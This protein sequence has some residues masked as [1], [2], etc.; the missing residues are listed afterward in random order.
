M[1]VGVLII[2]IKV[3]FFCVCKYKSFG[4]IDCIYCIKFVSV[5]YNFFFNGEWFFFKFF[6]VLKGYFCDDVNYFVSIFF[7]NFESNE[8]II[9]F[10]YRKFDCIRKFDIN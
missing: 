5:L 4:N 10:V 6:F 2:F 8:L 3:V 1:S 7:F 9:Y